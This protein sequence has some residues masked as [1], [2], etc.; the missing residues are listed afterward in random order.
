MSLLTRVTD[1]RTAAVAVDDI[2]HIKTRTGDLRT[3]SDRLRLLAQTLPGL[4]TS[5]GELAKINVTLDADTIQDAVEAVAGMRSLANTLP[6]MPVDA[7]LDVPKSQVKSVENVT[8]ELRL[9]VHANWI[10]FRDQE[11]PA[12]NEELVEA[13]AAGGVDMEDVRNELISAQTALMILKSRE[14]PHEGD[15][16]KYTDALQKL[17]A[18]GKKI[19]TLVEPVLAEGILR[20][21]TDE[22]ILLNWFTSE[23]MAALNELGILDRFRVRLR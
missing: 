17:R 3:L 11:L 23:R 13:L 7:P 16:D 5:L 15:V 9:F 12:I 19:S 22:G 21:Q 8:K 20:S 2:V 4:I 6:G 10:P 18:C 14:S 1:L